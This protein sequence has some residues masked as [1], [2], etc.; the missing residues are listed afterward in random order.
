MNLY[1][2]ENAYRRSAVQ[3]ASPIQL[4]L[5]LYDI[6]VKDLRNLADQVEARDYQEQTAAIRHALLVLQQL[7]GSLDPHHGGVLVESLSRF[8]AM[9]R[10]SMLRAQ[11]EQSIHLIDHLIALVLQVRSS[12]EEKQRQCQAAVSVVVAAFPRPSEERPARG[13]NG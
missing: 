7:E 1:V 9:V 13:W 3:N 5:M 12:F 2:T 11:A 6:L 4:V 8:Y 10:A